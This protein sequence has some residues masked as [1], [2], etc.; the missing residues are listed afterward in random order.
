MPKVTPRP[1]NGT[2]LALVEAAE[3]LFGQYGIENVSLRRI[4]LEAG[5]GNN[6]AINY[7]FNSREKL[8]RAIWNHR[9]PTLDKARRALLDTMYEQGRQNDPQTILRALVMPNYDLRDSLGVHRYA[10]FFRHALRW[11]EMAEIRN[12]QLHATPASSEA[13]RLFEALRPDIP[14]SLLH[15]RLR[16]GS[17]LFFDMVVERDAAVEAGRPVMPE[18]AFLKEC[19]EILEAI[20]LRHAPCP[21]C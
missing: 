4:R 7:H 18:E 15:Y 9:L 5:A 12:A 11:P 6:S 3:R 8:V 10:A 20:C 13:M 19:M 16:H 2:A 1:L 21:A 14:A 17:C